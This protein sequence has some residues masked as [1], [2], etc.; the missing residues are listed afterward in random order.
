MSESG[1]EQP[2]A[3]R[4]KGKP[5]AKGDPRINRQGKSKELAELEREFRQA[6]IDE[7][8]RPDEHDPEPDQ[9]KKR[10]NF[11]S[12]AR[13]WVELA[14]G[15]NLA[16]IEGLTERI[17]GKPVQPVGGVEGQP[18]EYRIVTNARLP[19]ASQ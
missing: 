1:S 9:E 6:I 7:L 19:R 16:A 14:K 17:L 13:R 4:G 12:L 18:I 5:F 8:C 10:T 3:K 2:T 15:G 11:Q